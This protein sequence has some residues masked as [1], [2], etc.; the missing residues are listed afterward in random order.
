MITLLAPEPGRTY[1]GGYLYNERVSAAA[2]PHRI[3]YR[4]IPAPYPLSGRLQ[5][6]GIEPGSTLL[7]DSLFFHD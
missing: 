2:G 5:E 1:S 6:L 3:I 7:L 4:N